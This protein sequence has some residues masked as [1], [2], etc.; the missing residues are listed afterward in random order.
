MDSLTRKASLTGLN[1]IHKFKNLGCG[2]FKGLTPFRQSLLFFS[3]IKKKTKGGFAH[4]AFA[5]I[6]ARALAKKWASLFFSGTNL[7]I[8]LF[9]YLDAST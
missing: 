1:K 5:G 4:R 6:I 2:E 7:F 3:L 9:I 8:Y